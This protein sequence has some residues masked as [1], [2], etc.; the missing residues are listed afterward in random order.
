[1]VERWA[2]QGHSDWLEPSQVTK[3][4]MDRLERQMLTTWL[5]SDS[6]RIIAFV[7]NG[8][9][10]MVLLMEGFE[11]DPGEHAIDPTASGVSGGFVLE[12]GQVDDY[13]DRDTVVLPEALRILRHLLADGVQPAD[14]TWQVDR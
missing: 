13:E 11:G 12:N 8:S 4:V 10:A 3:L 2:L 7:T 5:E 6:G 1:M 9:R 14:A